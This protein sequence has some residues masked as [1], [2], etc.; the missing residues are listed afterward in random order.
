M[1]TKHVLNTSFDIENY[2]A[3]EFLVALKSVLSTQYK[4]KYR[5]IIRDDFLF[6]I[7]ISSNPQERLKI[8]F[9]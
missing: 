3:Y 6:Y 7:F 2:A 4:S 1:L 9:N 5:I 8:N